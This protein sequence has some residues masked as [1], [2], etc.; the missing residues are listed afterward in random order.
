MKLAEPSILNY[1]FELLHEMEHRIG[2]SKFEKF[3]VL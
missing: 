1:F 2:Y 3:E